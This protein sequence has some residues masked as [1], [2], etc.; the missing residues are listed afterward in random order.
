MDAWSTQQINV[1]IDDWF[2]NKW[3]PEIPEILLSIL[4]VNIMVFFSAVLHLIFRFGSATSSCCFF[5]FPFLFLLFFNY[6]L[7]I[8]LT[9]WESLAAE[10]SINYIS[11]QTFYSFGDNLWNRNLWLK[12]LPSQLQQ[13]NSNMSQQIAIYPIVR[14][15]TF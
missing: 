1:S 13:N 11:K 8:P 10:C 3:I 2:Y 7:Q 5:L 9:T 15:F 6:L 14:L 4:S 12:M